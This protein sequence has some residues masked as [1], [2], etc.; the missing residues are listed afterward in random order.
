MRI[1]KGI[2]VTGVPQEELKEMSEAARKRVDALDK[3]FYPICAF[4]FA[5]ALLIA[6]TVIR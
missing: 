5:L 3:A 2:D 6:F 1:P 4:F